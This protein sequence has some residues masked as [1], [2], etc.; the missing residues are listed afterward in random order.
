MTAVATE[1]AVVF[2]VEDDDELR[3]S[4]DSLFRSIGLK[5]SMF[6]NAR[7]FMDAK[8]PDVTGCLVVDVRLPGL[9][10]LDFHDQLMK[11]GSAIPVIFM[12]G[13][14]DI[15]MSVRAMK[16]GAV[17]FLPKPF[18][19]QD[20]LDAVASALE[21]DRNRRRGERE[22][23]ALRKRYADLSLRERQVMALVTTG[24]MNKQVAGKLSLSEVTVKIHRGSAMRKMDA[25]TLADLI[26]M[27]ELL[28]LHRN[29]EDS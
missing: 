6:A 2:I 18:R 12:T 3:L 20:M 8:K 17:D 23:L 7:E 24:L 19:D 28:E 4:L 22:L 14:G 26:K 15:P 16:A 1:E 29:F 25:K 11:A 5:T 27:A 9:S 10:G 21:I 13:H